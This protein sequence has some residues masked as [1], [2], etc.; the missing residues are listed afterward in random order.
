MN[1]GDSHA[2]ATL[3]GVAACQDNNNCNGGSGED[4]TCALSRT[5][6]LFTNSTPA[7]RQ[8]EGDIERPSSQQSKAKEEGK[9]TSPVGDSKSN[10]T[11]SPA[12]LKDETSED[13]EDLQQIQEALVQRIVVEGVAD[14]VRDDDAIL[15]S[16]EPLPSTALAHASLDEKIRSAI[17]I[18][19]NFGP[20]AYAQRERRS[21]SLME[22]PETRTTTWT[23]ENEAGTESPNSHLFVAHPVDGQE[24]ELPRAQEVHD[25]EQAQDSSR[26]QRISKEG[27]KKNR[28]LMLCSILGLGAIVVGVVLLLVFLLPRRSG[29]SMIAGVDIRKEVATPTA[30]PTLSAR[31]YA[32]DLLPTDTIA[33]IR[34]H[35][36]SPPALAFQWLINNDAPVW[37]TL[38]NSTNSTDPDLQKTHILQRYALAILYYALQ[39]EHWYQN[40][41]WLE[42]GVDECLWYSSFDTPCHD[43]DPNRTWLFVDIA[44]DSNNL[45]GTVPSEVLQLLPNLRVFDIAHNHVTGTIPSELG[46]ATDLLLINVMDNQMTGTLPSQLPSKLMMVNLA[47]NQLTGTLPATALGQMTSLFDWNVTSN[48][49]GGPIPSGTFVILW[50]AYCCSIFIFQPNSSTRFLVT[51]LGT[52]SGLKKL[53]LGDNAWTGTLPTELSALTG[54]EELVV[55]GQHQLLSGSIPSA[56][57]PVMGDCGMLLCGCNCT[58]LC[59]RIPGA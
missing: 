25:L 16:I 13:Q 48:A 43:Q 52:L 1:L 55:R 59:E 51:E 9:R 18:S 29:V 11:R 37:E 47:E 41:G 23:G 30:A 24:L 10:S 22:R 39:G 44:L 3:V 36:E 20:R 40:T 6:G 12:A 8:E 4:L 33:N 2:E 38:W 46:L 57:C 7:S 58:A 53:W 31:D 21:P 14:N 5:R 19:S 56:L 28:T 27:N 15:S 17:S 32:L 35:P 26:K 54:L 50:K 49:F 34:K 42:P 45:Y